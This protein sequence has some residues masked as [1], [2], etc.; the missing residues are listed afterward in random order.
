M[1]II[2][3]DDYQDCVRYLS[4]FEKIVGHS[5][6]VYRDSPPDLASLASRFALAEALVLTRERTPISAALLD[7]LPRLRFISQTGRAG[8]HIDLSACTQRGIAVAETTSSPTA[9]AE[10]TWALIMASRR[11]LV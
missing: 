10:L 4:C 11:H 5:V 2:I 8:A 7:Q 3:P 6:Q 9:T 1:H